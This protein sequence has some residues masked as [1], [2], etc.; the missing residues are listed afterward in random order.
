MVLFEHI[1]CYIFLYKW[2]IRFVLHGNRQRMYGVIS[3]HPAQNSFFIWLTE[4]ITKEQEAVSKG[5]VIQFNYDKGCGFIDN[6]EGGVIYVH[7][8]AIKGDDY[9]RLM[10]GQRVNF[11]VRKSKKD[12]CAT[13]VSAIH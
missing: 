4:N 13:N 6:D 12:I 2:C 5:T 7:Y 1:S 8:S 3:I 11:D 10:E 9:H